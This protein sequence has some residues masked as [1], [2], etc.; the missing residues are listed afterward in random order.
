MPVFEQRTIID[1]IEIRRD[2]TVRVRL[3][4]QLL[5]D[6]VV[7]QSAWHR[8]QWHP[9]LDFEAHKNDINKHLTEMGAAEVDPGEWGRI[10]R[11]L[12]MEQTQD[13]IDAYNAKQG[14]D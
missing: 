9:G 6:G 14:G 11:V 12:A 4:K 13:V 5:R 2:G 7:I 3:D 1:Q 8:G 10:T